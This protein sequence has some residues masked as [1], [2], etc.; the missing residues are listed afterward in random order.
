MYALLLFA[1]YFFSR[2]FQDSGLA[3]VVS[4]LVLAA[5]YGADRV[6]IAATALPGEVDDA[7]TA[8][9]ADQPAAL[10]A[11]VALTLTPAEPSNT[12]AVPNQMSS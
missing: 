7:F 9:A 12:L 8:P 2:Y 1:C 11:A 4:A 6:D 5:L 10:V 3:Y